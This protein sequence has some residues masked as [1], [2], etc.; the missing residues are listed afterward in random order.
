MLLPEVSSQNQPK[1]L[2]SLS[3]ASSGNTR[4]SCSAQKKAL[5]EKIGTMAKSRQ[6]RRTLVPWQRKLSTSRPAWVQALSDVMMALGVPPIKSQQRKVCLYTD[7]TGADAPGEALSQA[8]M[9][10]PQLKS[11]DGRLESWEHVS[12]SEIDPK[13]RYLLS[14]TAKIAPS[15]EEHQLDVSSDDSKGR[16]VNVYICGPPCQ[17]FSLRGSRK[18][19]SDPRS[20]LLK[21]A[22]ERV[23]S[24]G[25]DVA[26]IEKAAEVMQLMADIEPQLLSLRLKGYL[27]VVMHLDP[28]KLHFVAKRKRTYIFLVKK[29]MS[30]YSDEAAMGKFLKDVFDK[31]AEVLT[32]DGPAADVTVVEDFSG[33]NHQH[34]AQRAKCKRPLECKCFELPPVVCPLHP[35]KCR[36]CKVGNMQDCKWRLSH[37]QWAWKHK[38]S[39]IDE[40]TP[41]V[42]QSIELFKTPCVRQMVAL[43]AMKS[44][45]SKSRS[46]FVCDVTQSINRSQ[47]RAD[48]KVGAICTSSKVL[49][50]SLSR[51]LTV[52]ELACIMGFRHESASALAASCG[53]TVGTK[54]VGNSM[55]VPTI[56]ACVV[57]LLHVL[58]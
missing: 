53:R 22:L 5:R 8:A 12:G 56:G 24:S 18:L 6:S 54:L 14:A 10:L 15:M 21:D 57:S 50:T 16:T 49:S 7:C 2:T 39:K 52:A 37:S 42:L 27:V 32:P 41:E 46:G 20:T 55:H 17:P 19:W 30:I 34:K 51:V 4:G 31:M 28:A 26:L 33:V 58:K 43:L 48:G 11:L 40:L 36:R 29:S 25:F 9:I 1:T 47:L 3:Q 38:V 13:I 44:S 35:C 45:K 23:A